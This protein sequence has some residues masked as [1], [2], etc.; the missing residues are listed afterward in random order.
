MKKT[1]ASLAVTA[2]LA[3][4]SAGANATLTTNFQ[5]DIDGSATGSASTYNVKNLFT[6]VNYGIIA[7]QFTGPN[8][9]NWMEYGIANF[10]TS[11]KSPSGTNYFNPSGYE[12]TATYNFQGTGSTTASSGVANIASGNFNLYSD[13]SIDFGMVASNIAGAADGSLVASFNVTGQDI[14]PLSNL[15]RP[16]A[17]TQFTVNAIAQTITPGYFSDT[18]HGDWSSWLSNGGFVFSTVTGNAL[19]GNPQLDPFIY[20]ALEQWAASNPILQQQG[21]EFVYVADGGAQLGFD[22]P[23]PA[24]LA[25][26]GLAL[27]G[28]GGL[29]RRKAA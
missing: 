18:T 28:L 14:S 2:A 22:V 4:A 13:D 16:T 6:G 11:T 10:E 26:T 5:F 29:R 21:W 27:L 25:L 19:V 12:F 15:A 8:T 1:L 7:L 24:S 23:E 17:N 9:F 20:P 3:V